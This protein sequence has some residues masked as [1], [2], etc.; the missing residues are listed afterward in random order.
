MFNYQRVESMTVSD[1]SHMSMTE[2]LTG[3]LCVVKIPRIL[4]DF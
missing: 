2:N 4:M 3:D 1:K